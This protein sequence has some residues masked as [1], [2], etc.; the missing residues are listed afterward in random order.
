MHS[1]LPPDHGIFQSVATW[2]GGVVTQSLALVLVL[3]IPLTSVPLTK[4]YKISLLD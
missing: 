3:G 4:N 2:G 1:Q